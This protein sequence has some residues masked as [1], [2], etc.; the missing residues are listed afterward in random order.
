MRKTI[1]T[2]I[3]AGAL[4]LPL[5]DYMPRTNAEVKQAENKA[6]RELD[7]IREIV[8]KNFLA[9][10]LE[11]VTPHAENFKNLR[12]KY[13][14]EGILERYCDVHKL[15]LEQAVTYWGKEIPDEEM[16]T[17]GKKIAERQQKITEGIS[18]VNNL[19]DKVIEAYTK[20][21]A[22]KVEFMKKIVE[23]SRQMPAGEI[24]S[25]EKKEE[26]VRKLVQRAYTKEE[27]SEY[28]KQ[29]C[30]LSHKLY[31]EMKNTLGIIKS[32]FSEHEF[33]ELNKY[34]DEAYE[35]TIKKYFP[36]KVKGGN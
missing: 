33:E 31:K 13:G 35:N 34:T 8:I 21:G 5:V 23:V 7:A 11:R 15:C 1:L 18:P 10:Y 12:K 16:Q 9:N 2:T 27:Y 20:W 24:E 32:F 22:K 36:D 26:Y 25:M 28:I 4:T 30:V 3:I 29:F 14:K 6:E 17:L 19:N